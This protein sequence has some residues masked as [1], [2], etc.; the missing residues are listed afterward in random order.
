ML[1][2]VVIDDAKVF[3]QKLRELGGLLQLP[4]A[5]RLLGRPDRV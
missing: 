3:N 2:G 1:D 4:P 5:A